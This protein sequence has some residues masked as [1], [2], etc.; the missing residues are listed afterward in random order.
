ATPFDLANGI[1]WN[2]FAAFS[3][4]ISKVEKLIDGV[5]QIN[6]GFRQGSYGNV[7]KVGEPYGAIEGE[8]VQRDEDGNLLLG[9]TTGLPFK[10]ALLGIVGDPNPDFML[11]LTNTISYR[12]FTL[13]FLVDIRKGGDLLALSTGYLRGFGISE[14]TAVNRNRTYIIPGFLADPDDPTQA[15]R[16]DNG[17]KVPNNIPVSPQNFWSAAVSGINTNQYRFSAEALIYDATVYRLRELSLTYQFPD[18]LLTNLPFGS[19]SVTLVGRNLWFLAPNL[20]HIDP[21]VSTYGA[22]NT[23]GIDQYA[24]PTTKNYGVNVKFT[25]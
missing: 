5:D 2:I 15:L 8:M 19:A 9:T 23:Q 1:R 13:G 20:P 21:E 25:F 3:R 16:D 22:G 11:G 18:N 24:P 17:N 14:E 4:N 7:L 10:A 6:P 12:G